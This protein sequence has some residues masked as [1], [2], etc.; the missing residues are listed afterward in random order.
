MK[1][2]PQNQYSTHTPCWMAAQVGCGDYTT[3]FVQALISIDAKLMGH[4]TFIRVKNTMT[5]SQQT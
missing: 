3:R 1:H 4:N 5:V 2:R